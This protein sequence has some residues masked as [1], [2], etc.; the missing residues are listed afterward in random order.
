LVLVADT[1]HPRFARLYPRAA[2]RADARGAAAHRRQLLAN[3]HGRVVE[4][5][6]GNGL[7]FAHYPPT[8][9]EVVAIEPEPTLREF[10]RDAANRAPVRVTVQPGLADALPFAD[11]TFDAAVASLV[12]CSV[13][14]QATALAELRRVLKPGGELRF[15]E[16]VVP[17]TGPKR[18]LLRFADRS[19]LWPKLAGG[20]HPARDTGAAIVAAGFTVEECERIEFSA[21]PPLEPKI[22]YLLGRARSA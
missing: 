17:L 3:L 9:T 8:V 13:P 18:A 21:A 2:A 4:V 5:G 22:P 6:A 11:D 15:Y 16:H 10:A 19:G 20:C 1:C 12:L 7:N 14:D